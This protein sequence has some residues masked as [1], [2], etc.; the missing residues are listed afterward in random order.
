[1]A[2]VLVDLHHVGVLELSNDLRLVQEPRHRPR[3]GV[4]ARQN[5]LEGDQAVEA[6]LPSFVDDCHAAATQLTQYFVS[7]HLR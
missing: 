7:R 1:M 3:A 6:R 5:H 4:G 2:A